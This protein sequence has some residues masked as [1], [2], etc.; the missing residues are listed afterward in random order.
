MA[1]VVTRTLALLA[2]PPKWTIS[3]WSDERRFLSPEASSE[4][5]RW[6]TARA[7][8]QRGVMDAISDH[9]VRTVVVMKGS[10]V[11]WTEILNNSVGY[12]MDQDPAPLLVIQPTIELA[13]AWSKE[14]LAPMLRDTPVLRGKVHEARSRDS[15]NTIRVKIFP[16]G[17]MAIIGANAP[18]ELAS[19]PIRVVLADEVDR[20]PVSAGTEG[21]PMALAAKRQI[22]FW[23][24]KTLLGSTPVLASTSVINREFKKSDQRRFFIPC[25][26][27]DHEQHLQWSNVRWD[28][29]PEGKHMPETAHYVCENCGSV[30]DD[31]DRW[32]ATKKGKWRATAVSPSGIVGFHIP[33]LLSPWLT[34]EDIAREFLAAKDDPELLQV[35]TNTILGEPWEAPS[36]KV[37]GKSLV[38]RGEAY[39]HQTVPAGVKI[40]VAGVDVQGD[41]LELQIDGYGWNEETWAVRY[42]VLHGDPAQQQVWQDLDA[43][44]L[45]RYASEEGR[46]LRVRA[47]CIDTGGHHGNQVHEFCNKRRARRVF[48]TK[49]AAGTRPIWPKRASKTKDKRNEVF[50]VGVDTG[51]DAL[52]GRLKISKPGPGYQHFP[53]GHG[54]D[55]AYFDQL[56]SERVETRKKEGRPYRVWVLP[57]GKRNEAL[58]TKVLA[59][60]ARH[61]LPINL[62]NL[63][64][65]LKAVPAPVARAINE[66]A[67]AAPTPG[68][69]YEPQPASPEQALAQAPQADPS[70]PME[71]PAGG[72]RRLRRR[73]M[74]S[75]YMGN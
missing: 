53:A 11:G 46:E 67:L 28:K 18:A 35:W 69:A 16:G 32:D 66:H 60:A 74:H 25:H 1:A 71:K 34:L 31:I 19:R 43:L 26:A 24:R 44:L 39:T 4:P 45:E 23:N 3:E 73:V 30:W 47:C 75:T 9:G 62:K 58:D 38:N 72:G 54:Y 12:F 20:Y 64:V 15:G 61:S 5:G 49:G 40:L 63:E 59:M 17:R 37:D 21:D 14:R 7:E 65:L 50:L 2:P 10:Q 51:K 41:R 33:G 36:E 70:K 13:E 57:A 48:P 22:T 68:G 56:T 8:Y 55:E 6:N 52:Y 29:S 42:E 27:C